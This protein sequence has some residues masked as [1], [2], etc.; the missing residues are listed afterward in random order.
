MF[1]RKGAK[2]MTNVL[3]NADNIIGTYEEKKN[4]ENKE[5]S[6]SELILLYLKIRDVIA[7]EEAQEL[8]KKYII[9]DKTINSGRATIKGTRVTPEDIGR[10]LVKRENMDIEDI[11][12]EY[13]SLDNEE[14]VLAGLMY[15]V[16]KKVSFINILF[17]KWNFYWMRMCQIT[18]KKR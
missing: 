11:M 16:K 5:S 6:K 1:I 8:M 12:E 3:T 13:P 15:Y 7:D 9:K 2:I 14:Q 10:I 17:S 18:I 4:I